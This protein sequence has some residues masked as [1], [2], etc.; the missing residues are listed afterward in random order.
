MRHEPKG[1]KMKNEKIQSSKA[2]RTERQGLLEFCLSH[3]NSDNCY[4]KKSDSPSEQII[5]LNYI[6]EEVR[7][8][9][10][11]QEINMNCEAM[12]GPYILINTP[13]GNRTHYIDKYRGTL[14]GFNIVGLKWQ[15]KSGEKYEGYAT[16][17]DMS[18]S[19]GGFACPVYYPV[20]VKYKQSSESG[21]ETK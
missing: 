3:P 15:T 4:F 5:S 7:I 21:G 11:L 17:A 13:L 8:L 9:R 16:G 19:W 6:G 18:K 10:A 20:I 2:E 1:N 14:K 12:D